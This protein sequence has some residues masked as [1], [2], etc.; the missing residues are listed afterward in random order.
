MVVLIA[1]ISFVG[2][3]A[4][5]IGGAEKGILFT[6]LFA[7]GLSSSTAL[8]L[9]F[10]HLSKQQ[11]HLSGLLASGILI[12]CGTM[13]PRILFVCSVVNYTLVEMLWLPMLLMMLGFYLPAYWIWTHNKLDTD[14]SPEVKQNPLALSSAFFFGI[15]LLLIMLLSN[16][17]QEWFGNTGTL[18]LAAISG[19]TDVD[20]ITLALGR[21]SANGLLANTAMLGIFIAAAV[22]SLIKMGMACV[23]GAKPLRQFVIVPVVGS[24]LLGAGGVVVYIWL[25]QVACDGL[26]PTRQITS[27]LHSIFGVALLMRLVRSCEGAEKWLSSSFCVSECW[28]GG[29]HL[30]RQTLFNNRSILHDHH[31]VGEMLDNAHML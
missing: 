22:N 16:L 18:L 20:A 19:I 11:T 29:K 30:G 27:Y 4:I 31:L 23:I 6:C 13:F 5:K 1:G 3:F 25:T 24:V 14:E 15:V 10:S 9:Q 7:G 17:L 12:S 28:G 26:L 8:T 21:Q 2:Y